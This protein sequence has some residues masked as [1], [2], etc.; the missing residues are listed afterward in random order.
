MAPV[1]TLLP[2]G[3]FVALLLLG[4]GSSG[5]DGAS[6]KS[7]AACCAAAAD[8]ASNVCSSDQHVC[9]RTCSAD[10]D[11]PP[12]PKS[13]TAKCSSKGVCEGETKD[14]D[15]EHPGGSQGGGGASSSGGETGAGGA[16]GSVG[17]GG[18]S[19]GGAIGASGAKGT[20]GKAS[21]GGGIGIGDPCPT[22]AA[23]E[24]G[25]CYRPGG[26]PGFC[27]TTCSVSFDAACSGSSP[28]GQNA[29][30]EYLYC[31]PFGGSGGRCF[32]GCVNSPTVC[33]KFLG[34]TCT[35]V[36]DIANYGGKVCTETL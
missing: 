17:S 35:S 25:T 20:G 27:T 7:F 5:G 29:S 10:T 28:G 16:G 14:L 23:C 32:P 33:S 1:R 19:S 2:I 36:K 12:E 11:C 8:C 4:C 13:G 26:P 9:T 24:S 6:K 3:A 15:C 21:T 31:L 22:D 30:G 18:L 34:V